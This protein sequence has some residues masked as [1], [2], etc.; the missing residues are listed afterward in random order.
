[1]KLKEIL[2]KEVLLREFC[3]YLEEGSDAAS[4]QAKLAKLIDASQDLI[5]KPFGITPKDPKYFIAGSARL[6]LYK[7]LRKILNLKD[8]GD[9]DM[10]IPGKQEWIK[11]RKYW[12]EISSDQIKSE[13]TSEES[14]ASQQIKSEVT[15]EE[16]DKNIWRPTSDN[17]IEAFNKWAPQLAGVKGV[18]DFSVRS[19]DDILQ[20]AIK[21]PI[22]GYYFMP[23]IDII[24]YK[25]A[26]NRE[27]EQEIVEYLFKF[28]NAEGET[29][30]DEIKQKL[31]AVFGNDQDEAD[32]FL[33]P[34][35]TA[36]AI[37]PSTA[38]P[39]TQDNV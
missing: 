18:K 11:A 20:E 26:L 32:G 22:G 25:L 30:R 36:R 8:V 13:V 4:I 28:R 2:V 33:A 16:L 14:T 37:Q 5:F 29:E 17:S 19:S 38:A 21:N 39:T 9:L 23:M 35:L 1:M 7:D 10:V 34:A 3:N 31:L 27:K 6:Y 15:S 24:D 12:T